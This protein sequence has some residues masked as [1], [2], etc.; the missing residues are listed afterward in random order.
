M[1]NIK[2][3]KFPQNN[4]DFFLLQTDTGYIFRQLCMENPK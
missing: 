1:Y 2:V 4:L 3:S